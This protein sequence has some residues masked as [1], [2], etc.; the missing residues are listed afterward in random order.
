MKKVYL[1]YMTDGEMNWV[2]DV[3]TSREEALK[4]I[5]FWNKRSEY[6]KMYWITETI[7]REK[8]NFYEED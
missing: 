3:Y 5:T 8:S 4:Y 1:V 2:L 7:L 6:P